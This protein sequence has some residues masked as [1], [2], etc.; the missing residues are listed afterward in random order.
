MTPSLGSW[1]INEFENLGK[2]ESAPDKQ[3]LRVV[4]PTGKVE[5]KYFSSTVAYA[6]SMLLYEKIS[7]LSSVSS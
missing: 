4:Y 2:W 3:N 6:R 1:I 5:F 7:Y